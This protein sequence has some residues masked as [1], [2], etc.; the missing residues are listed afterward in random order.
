M[1]EEKSFSKQ[2]HARFY[3]TTIKINGRLKQK[4]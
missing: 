1:K 2:L 3:A 4:F